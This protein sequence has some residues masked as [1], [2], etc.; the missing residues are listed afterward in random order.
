MW[1]RVNKLLNQY[2]TT[3]KDGEI[4][5]DWR[6]NNDRTRI[7]K[8]CRFQEDVIKSPSLGHEV[9]YGLDPII[10]VKIEQNS[11]EQIQNQFQTLFAL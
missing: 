5:E 7:C 2:S 11:K 6:K 9:L 1:N 10:S 8:S 3:Q 4:Y